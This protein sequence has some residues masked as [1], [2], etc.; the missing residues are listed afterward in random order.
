MTKA[1]Y[2]R[3]IKTGEYG[4]SVSGEI[5]D[6]WNPAATVRLYKTN[7][8]Y[9]YVL[10]SSV[11]EG[12]AG[13]AGDDPMIQLLAELVGYDINAAETAVFPSNEQGHML[14]NEDTL[15]DLPGDGRF[16]EVLEAAGYEVVEVDA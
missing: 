3:D 9:G 7:D 14:P 6:Y 1:Q 12:S 8:D 10:V 2:V 11:P 13:M 15:A 16:V 5:G 4:D